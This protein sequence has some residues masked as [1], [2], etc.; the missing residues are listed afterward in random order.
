[1]DMKG[2]ARNCSAAILAQAAGK[3]GIAAVTLYGLLKEG[4]SPSQGARQHVASVG[5]QL[6]Q[7]WQPYCECW[8]VACARM[9]TI[10]SVW[11]RSL[12]SCSLHR[13]ESV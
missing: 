9:L 2:H 3:A 5:L 6:Q 8:P 7:S 12:G 4:H 10:A 1:M 13:T 11:G